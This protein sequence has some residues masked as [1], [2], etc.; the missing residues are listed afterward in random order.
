MKRVEVLVLAMFI[1]AAVL[2][3]EHLVVG[4]FGRNGGT[5]RADAAITQAEP[6]DVVKAV[7]EDAE[8]KPAEPAA[9]DS[10]A[11]TTRIIE[12]RL[13]DSLPFVAPADQPTDQP[14][15]PARAAQPRAVDDVLRPPLEKPTDQPAGLARPSR[16]A[17]PRASDDVLPAPAAG[18]PTPYRRGR[19]APPAGPYEATV[20]APS[21]PDGAPIAGPYNY[22]STNAPVGAAGTAPATPVYLPPGPPATY[23]PSGPTPADERET[24]IYHLNSVPAGNIAGALNMAIGQGAPDSGLSLVPETVGNSLM[25]RGTREKVEQARRLLD[26]MDRPPAMVRLEVEVVEVDRAKAKKAEEATEEEKAADKAVKEAGERPDGGTVLLHAVITTLD[27]QTAQ[28][29]IGRNE[30]QVSG[31]MSG[32]RGQTNTVTYVNVGSTINLTPRIG[33]DAV[34][35]QLD[36]SDSRPTPAEESVVLAEPKEGSP[37]RSSGTQQFKTQTTVRLEDGKPL[38]LGGIGR[39]GKPGKEITMTLT[40]QILRPS[41]AKDAKPE[42]SK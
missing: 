17:R 28:I 37:I 15:Q 18:T 13:G 2:V 36:I 3:C 1:L 16:T 42:E 33:G 10:K 7:A 12:H 41:E 8:E 5:A 39:G 26:Q 35:L 20:A 11:P 32:P 38:P 31:S 6:L 22:P 19:P 25:L 23:A 24:V 14:A 27:N 4:D 30:P 9:E 34:V 21:F 29:M 40:A